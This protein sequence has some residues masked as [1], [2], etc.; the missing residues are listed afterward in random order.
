MRRLIAALVL[1]ATCV[2]CLSNG[3]LQFDA[4]Q[5]GRSMNPDHT[6]GN[7]TTTFKSSDTIYASVLTSNAGAGTISVRWTFDGRVVSEPS[8]QVRYKGSGAT[9]FSLTNS[10]RFPPGNYKVEVSIDGKPV[11]DRA[12]KVEE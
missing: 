5:L 12:F 10:S 6:V 7:H 2:G 8:K 11:A 1:S 4:L 9:E 3:T